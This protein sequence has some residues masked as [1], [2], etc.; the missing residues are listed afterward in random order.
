MGAV[1]GARSFSSGA[2]ISA[3]LLCNPAF[4]HKGDM[5]KTSQNPFAGSLSGLIRPFG[6][7]IGAFSSLSLAHA[8]LPFCGGSSK[9]AAVISGPGDGQ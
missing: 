6:E 5:R 9:R 8:A 2:A 7:I 3:A 1:Q 4:S